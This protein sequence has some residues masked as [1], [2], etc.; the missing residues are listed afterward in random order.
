M[1]II[2]TRVFYWVVVLPEKEVAWNLAAPHPLGFLLT[3]REKRAYPRRR[4]EP[5]FPS[6]IGGLVDPEGEA[7]LPKTKAGTRVPLSQWV[8]LLPQGSKWFLT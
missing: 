8:F 7:G 4:V 3:L 1:K 6:P 2:E 5:R